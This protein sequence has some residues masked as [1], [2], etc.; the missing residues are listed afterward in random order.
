MSY[1]ST[2]FRSAVTN[3]PHAVVLDIS[4]PAGDGFLVAQRIQANAPTCLPI[5]FLTASK[6]RDFRKRAYELGAA[7]FFEKPY[8]PEALVTA[9]NQALGN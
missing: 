5:I 6:R 9:L 8:D 4:L 3:Q 2:D 1:I 7:G